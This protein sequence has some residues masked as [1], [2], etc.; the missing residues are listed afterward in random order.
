MGIVV[1]LIMLTGLW[2]A[3]SRRSLQRQSLYLVAALLMIG[4]LWNAAWYGLQHT[5]EFWG[6]AA[7]VSGVFMMVWSVILLLE[8]LSKRV[9]KLISIFVLLGL[10]VSFLL[11]A[12]SLIQLNLGMDIIR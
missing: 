1:T 12:I 6:Q 8:N 11:Y 5:D 3:V 9:P 4:G 10:S 7:L 2:S